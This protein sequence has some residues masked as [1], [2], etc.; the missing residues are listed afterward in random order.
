[1]LYNANKAL[2]DRDDKPVMEGGKPVS[3]GMIA[4]MALDAPVPQSP[5]VLTEKLSRYKL[6]M[7]IHGATGPVE[8]T[9][10]EAAMIK[11]CL[12]EIPH[13]TP[14]V[15]GRV[16]EDLERTGDDS[17]TASVVPIR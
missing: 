10:E 3:L 5:N 4:V 17:T 6:Q 12:A 14:L 9:I 8:I 1:M 16:V 11:K 15:I 7:R 13:F 2:L